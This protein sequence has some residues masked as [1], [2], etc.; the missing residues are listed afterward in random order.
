MVSR[1][2]RA[3]DERGERGLWGQTKVK[4]YLQG[5]NEHDEDETQQCTV[6]L[7]AEPWKCD[8]CKPRTARTSGPHSQGTETEHMNGTTNRIGQS[9]VTDKAWGLKQS[10]GD[11]RK[12]HGSPTSL[13]RHSLTNCK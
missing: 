3:E 1:S 2:A 6:C 5:L 13:T 11:E 12:G 9:R 7:Q 4:P 10:E 8:L